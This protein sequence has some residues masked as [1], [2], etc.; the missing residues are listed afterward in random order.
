MY[1]ALIT[2]PFTAVSRW[3][4]FFYPQWNVP[5]TTKCILSNSRR[6]RH[7][8]TYWSQSDSPPP[9]PP[10]PHTHTHSSSHL[11][12]SYSLSLICQ[13]DIR[14]HEDPHHHHYLRLKISV[15]YPQQSVPTLCYTRGHLPST[16]PWI[17]E[18]RLNVNCYG[19]RIGFLREQD[20]LRHYPSP[21]YFKYVRYVY[22]FFFYN[23]MSCNFW[24]SSSRY[25]TQRT[26]IRLGRK[27]PISAIKHPMIR[28]DQQHLKEMWYR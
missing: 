16:V 9:P 10:P 19:L 7:D 3:S 2:G 13:P 17:S 14:G 23:Y 26:Q 15:Q 27:D 11:R 5:P 8:Y 20:I 28:S 18:A 4:S 12:V 24:N 21:K 22:V 1:A 25:Q 6:P